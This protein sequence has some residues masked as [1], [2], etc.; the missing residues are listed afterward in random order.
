MGRDRAFARHDGVPRHHAT[1]TTIERNRRRLVSARL[2][3]ADLAGLLSARR[4]RSRGIAT[5]G[6]LRER[7]NARDRDADATGW[8]KTGSGE[9]PGPRLATDRVASARGGRVSNTVQ[10]DRWAA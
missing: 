3:A 4:L 7:A 6:R 8:R 9:G 2:L 10:I 5:G 1:R